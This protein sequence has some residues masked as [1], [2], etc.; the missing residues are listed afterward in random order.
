MLNKIAIDLTWVKPGNS[1]GIESYIRNLMDGI[2]AVPERD[3]LQFLLLITLDNSPSFKHY[4]EQGVFD[5][6]VCPIYSENVEQT[7]KWTNFHLDD[8]VHGLGI[9][10]CFV[11]YYRMPVLKHGKVKYIV[12][13][14]DLQALHYPEYFSKKKY[15]WLKLAWRNT[16]RNADRIIAISEFVKNDILKHYKCAKD[17]VSVIY[18]PIKLDDGYADFSHLSCRLGIEANKYYYT[19]SSLH[20][21]KNLMTLCKVVKMLK[22]TNPSTCPKL[23][24]TGIRGGHENV[25][26]KYVKDNGLEENCIFTGF[27]SNSERN[28]LL[29]NAD[30]FLFASVFEGFGMPI[31]EAMMMGTRV[32][33]TDK[34]SLMEVSCGKS[35]YVSD[36]YDVEEW[37]EKIKEAKPVTEMF[38]QYRK[39]E[40]ARQYLELIKSTMGKS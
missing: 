18:N 40:I 28:T 26:Y 3:S 35:T 37:I 6:Y 29:K 9:K 23:V 33:S 16:V 4:L 8:T 31:I 17:K 24:I 1:G 12:T 7:I 2:C 13:I 20:P 11:P 15:Y 38:P 36:P 5:E 30:A 39:E 19:I 27:I 32:V 14:H 34:T 22:D 21:H 25:I 10:W